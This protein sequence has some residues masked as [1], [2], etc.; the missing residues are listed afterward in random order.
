MFTGIIKEVGKVKVIKRKP[1]LIELGIDSNLIYPQVNPQDSISVNGVCLTLI[2]K[3]KNLLFFEVVKSTLQISNLKR[4]KISD[5]VNLEPA[6]TSQDKLSGHFVLGHVDGE[7]SLKR[8]I[9]FGD[10]WQIEVEL[11]S[12][13]KKFILENGCVALEGISLTV[14]KVY[15]TYFT[16]DIVPFTYKNTNLQYKKIGDKLNIECDYLVKIIKHIKNGA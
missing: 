4:L 1:S 3:E 11:P 13:F 12:K 15:P 2:R 10:W 16:I 6:L 9:P 5:F 14:K 7:V 8:I